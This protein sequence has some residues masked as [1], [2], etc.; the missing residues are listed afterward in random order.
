MS[1]S[2]SC[3]AAVVVSTVMTV[4]L[5]SLNRAKQTYTLRSAAHDVAARMYFTRIASIVRNRDCRI[6]VTSAASYVIE[7]DEAPWR[8]IERITMPGGITIEATARPEFHRRGNVAPT[9][10]L[11][12]R[13]R[14]GSSRRVIVNVNGRVR[15]V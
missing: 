14:A 2:E 1:L 7:C 3:I 6:T 15:I 4:A 5:P 10:T 11:T 8:V 12:V 13:N 9:A